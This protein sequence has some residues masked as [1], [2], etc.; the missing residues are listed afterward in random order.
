MK[1]TLRVVL[2]LFAA[3]ALAAPVAH[4]AERMWIGFHDDPS[5]RWVEDR[6]SRIESSA[7][8]GASVMRLLV[9]WDETARERPAL[10]SNPFDAAYNF[11]DL[12]EA[13]RAAQ[14]E[15]MEVLLSLV[16]TPRWANGGKTP[17]VMP[18]RL[19]DFTAFAQ[20]IERVD[21]VNTGAGTDTITVAGGIDTIVAALTHA[22]T[23]PTR[24]ALRV[25]W[26]R[27]GRPTC[28]DS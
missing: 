18:R 6:Q 26:A 7:S 13:I 23:G 16:G 15:D 17:N 25:S 2:V 5:F 10:A 27:S 28:R 20:A 11:S 14:K 19:G 22:S 9:R 8:Q 4:A 12:D 21:E 24:V 1:R 3:S